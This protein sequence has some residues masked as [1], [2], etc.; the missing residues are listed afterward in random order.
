MSTKPILAVF[1]VTGNQGYSTAHHV[2]TSPTLSAKYNVRAISR[3]ASHPNLTSLSS[4]GAEITCADMSDP[5]TLPSAL[6]NVSYL[7]L[8]TTTQY[9][10]QSRA[11][12]TQH[13]KNVCTEALK[14]GVRYIIFSSMSHPYKITS[15]KLKNVEHFDVKAEIETYIRSLPVQSAFFAPASFMQNFHTQIKPRPSEDD[16]GTYVLA[17]ML[18]DNALVPYL[19]ITDTGKFIGPILADPDKYA[20]KFFAAAERFYTRDEVVKIISKVTGKTVRHVQLEDEVVKSHFPEGL[21][22]ALGEMWVLMREYGY[23][24]EGEQELVKWAREQVE[25]ELTGLEEFLR[26]SKFTLD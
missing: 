7:F 1:G 15:G 22:E 18:P 16:D 17:D 25:G 8:L 11:I 3:T 21:R 20:G 26:K 13:A 9:T 4:L 19:D 5:S 2:L 24:G 10:G 6:K 12:E 23:Y 14:Q